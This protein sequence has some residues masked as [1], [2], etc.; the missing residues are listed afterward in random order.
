MGYQQDL[1]QIETNFPMAARQTARDGRRVTSLVTR[2]L[3]GNGRPRL[4][5][6]TAPMT[7]DP[8]TAGTKDVRELSSYT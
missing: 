6:S 1:H 5:Y 8:N 4:H 7:D 3:Y 2:K